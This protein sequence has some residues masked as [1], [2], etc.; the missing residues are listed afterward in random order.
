MEAADV[1]I[2]RLPE[3]LDRTGLKRTLL[4][5]EVRKGRFPKPVKLAPDSRAVGWSSRAVQEWI[6]ERLAG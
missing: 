3:V 2:L 5:S 1:R 4:L 6:T